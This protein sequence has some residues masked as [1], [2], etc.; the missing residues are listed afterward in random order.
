[1]PSTINIRD[2]QLFYYPILSDIS[3]LCTFFGI[4]SS[5]LSTGKTDGKD[6]IFFHTKVFTVFMKI[7]CS[8]LY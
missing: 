3:T 1:M 2:L 6:F 4:Y 5:K 7:I 8:W